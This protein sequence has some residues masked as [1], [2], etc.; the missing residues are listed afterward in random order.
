MRTSKS[1]PLLIDSVSIPG[2]GILGM[3]IAPSK[4]GQSV[5]G[6]N[7]NRDLTTDIAAIKKWGAVLVI[8]L[9]EEHEFHML[10]INE[11]EVEVNKADMQWLHFPIKDVSIPDARFEQQWQ[12][13]VNTIYRCLDQGEKVLVHCRGGLGR[14]GLLVA[15]LLMAYGASS[16]EAISKVREARTG[17]IETKEQEDYVRSMPSATHHIITTEEKFKGCLLAGAVG[18][19]LGAPVE[20][21]SRESILQQFGKSGIRDFVPAYGRQGAITDDT[22]M[23][24]FTAEGLL[25][26]WHRNEDILVSVSRSYL[27]WLKTQGISH[28]LLQRQQPFKPDAL[29]NHPDLNHQRA[30][31]KTCLSALQSMKQLGELATNNSKGCGGVMRV[32]PVALFYYSLPYTD[33][34][35]EKVFHTGGQIAAIT[36]GHPTSIWSSAVLA[37]IIYCLLHGHSLPDAL[38]AAKVLLIKQPDH[39]ETLTSLE[40]AIALAN[41]D[42]SPSGAIRQL[43][44]GWIAEEA[45]AISVYCVLKADSL[46]DALVMAVNHDGDSDSTGAIAGNLAGA[47]YGIQAVPEKWLSS[48]E[49]H[50]T[51]TSIAKKMLNF[52][53][54]G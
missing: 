27:H 35:L 47:I 28:P 10:G 20:F 11:L 16:D 49:L 25:E 48:L 9:I 54:V 42:N 36:H 44:E 22:Q 43:G 26:S 33:D 50:D 32:A 24:L 4:K 6:E 53:E 31:G 21:M 13:S 14:T 41:S 29:V 37:L 45:L 5:F 39:K 15:R 34:T 12:Q 8:S 38:Q 7:W 51:L 46:E 18:D 17:A 19:A 52:R 23:T 2:G 3:T 40:M 30:P 1:N